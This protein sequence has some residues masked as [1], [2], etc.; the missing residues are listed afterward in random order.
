[1]PEELERSLDQMAKLALL[2]AGK[3]SE[4]PDGR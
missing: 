2:L 4:P 3:T 1:L